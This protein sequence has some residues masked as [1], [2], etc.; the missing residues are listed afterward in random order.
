MLPAGSQGQHCFV[1]TAD[2]LSCDVHGTLFGKPSDRQEAIKMIQAARNGGL[3]CTAFC[4]DKKI[5]LN[6]AWKCKKHIIRCV[7]SECCFDVPD[8]RL[9]AYLAQPFVFSSAGAIFVEGFGAQ[10]VKEICGSYTTIQ[11]LPMYELRQA[12][13]EIGF[14]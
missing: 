1:L 3:T 12:L 11:G 8:Y 4:L 7:A 14:Y 6:N 13:T 2:T 9:D 10:F 5:W